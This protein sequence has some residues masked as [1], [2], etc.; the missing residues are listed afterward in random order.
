MHNRGHIVSICLVMMLFAA[1]CSKAPKGILTEKEMQRVQADM[2]IADAMLGV[3]YKDYANDTAK[4][5]LYESV[6]QKHNITQAKY[7]SSLVWYG[8]NLDIYMKVYERIASDLGKQI[9]DLGDIQAEVTPTTKNDSVDIWPR[10]SFMTFYPKSV[11]NGVIFDIKPD[12]NF[13]SGSSFVLGM[14]VWGLPEG[15]ESY[16]EIRINAEQRDTTIRATQTITKDGYYQ[17]VVRTL[18]TRQVRRVYGSIW[19]NNAD[20]VYH[21]IYI[22]SLDLMRYNYGTEF[23]IVGETVVPE[24]SLSAPADE[25]AIP[26]EE[27]SE[28]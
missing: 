16:P 8:K 10:R 24:T 3:N 14:R 27:E 12:K 4:V 5:A 17:T 22:D 2:L 13:P 26:T 15:M 1:S 7:D 23:K 20:S 6:F 25:E 11:F 19:M 28:K 21:K 18:A 9:H